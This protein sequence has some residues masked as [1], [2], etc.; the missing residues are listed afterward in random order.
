MRT[1]VFACQLLFST[2]AYSLSIE[3]PDGTYATTEVEYYVDPDFE[4]YC[5]EPKIIHPGDEPNFSCKDECEY[6]DDCYDYYLDSEEVCTHYMKVYDCENDN[7]TLSL[8]LC[9]SVNTTSEFVDPQDCYDKCDKVDA[10]QT[11][12]CL[13]TYYGVVDCTYEMDQDK[14]CNHEVL[15]DEIK[16]NETCSNFCYTNSKCLDFSFEYEGKDTCWHHID[17]VSVSFRMIPKV[18]SNLFSLVYES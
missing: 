14:C 16:D 13:P 3:Y 5:I 17:I 9:L 1:Y 7:V 6:R 2:L 4:D 18:F 15:L 11:C 10:C 8:D 12:A